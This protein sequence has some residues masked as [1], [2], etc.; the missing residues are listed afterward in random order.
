G[1]HSGIGQFPGDMRQGSFTSPMPGMPEM[2]SMPHG[3]QVTSNMATIMPSVTGQQLASQ[4]ILP[5]QVVVPDDDDSCIE[6]ESEEAK[7]ERLYGI[8]IPDWCSQ[9]QNLPGVYKDVKEAATLNGATDTCT[10]YPILLASELHRDVLGQIWSR[11]NKATPGQL[12]DMELRMMLGLIALGQTGLKVERL[13]LDKL[14]TCKSAPIPSIPEDILKPSEGSWSFQKENTQFSQDD[15]RSSST[16]PLQMGINEDQS[17][18][19]LN[20][21]SQPHE[22]SAFK[23]VE[24]DTIKEGFGGFANWSVPNSS[25]NSIM[26]QSIMQGQS[27]P[28]FQGFKSA[29]ISSEANSDFGDFQ[30]SASSI[31]SIVTTTHKTTT[32][33]DFTNLQANTVSNVAVSL[34]S[35]QLK[36]EQSLFNEIKP[37]EWSLQNDDGSAAEF[38]DFASFSSAESISKS[39]HDEGIH[40][41]KND[42][43]A[44]FPVL[45][46]PPRVDSSLTLKIPASLSKSSS[47]KKEETG[48]PAGSTPQEGIT[49]TADKYDFL[50][51]LGGETSV[52]SVPPTSRNK[53]D[54]FGDFESFEQV[55]PAAAEHEFGDFQSIATSGGPTTSAHQV[56]TSSNTKSSDEWGFNAFSSVTS[57]SAKNELNFSTASSSGASNNLSNTIPSQDDFGDFSEFQSSHMV[58]GSPNIKQD[59]NGVMVGGFGADDDSCKQSRS[60]VNF[61]NTV[62]LDYTQRYKQLCGEEEDADQHA[63]VWGRCLNSCLLI[64]A[65]CAV[66][67]QTMSDPT[68]KQEVLQS[69][70]GMEYFT[71]IIEI[72]KVTK[73]VQVSLIKTDLINEKLKTILEEMNQTW[74][75]IANFLTG[76]NLEV[77]SNI[78]R[79]NF[80]DHHVQTDE[81]KMIACGLCLLNVNK[82]TDTKLA[83]GGREYHSTCANFWCNRVDSILPSLWPVNSLI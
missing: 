38:S 43:F 45:T 77:S 66:A 1:Y 34:E 56:L 31:D 65:T 58:G 18:S 8:T 24:S 23:S 50:R 33:A 54:N 10:L 6:E 37:S 73:R 74:K 39:S 63:N 83:Y 11:V 2:T 36:T 4:Q 15:S 79:E 70:K 59:M 17:G 48:L 13:T 51:D 7:L 76:T 14:A 9:G 72:F 25:V 75:N 64:L 52:F 29:E 20:N 41:N 71:A 19:I 80:S 53:D 81:D 21:T 46:M 40:G 22:C 47:E 49:K 26:T 16:M 55:E 61:T 57:Q 27:S 5:G 69:K 60:I 3:M 42:N 30:G 12:N 67:V 44:A 68:I 32:V 62:P 35:F 28:R 78:G 82:T